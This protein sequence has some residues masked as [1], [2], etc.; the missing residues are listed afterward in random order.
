MENADCGLG[1]G[2]A[3]VKAGADRWQLLREP[4]PSQPLRENPGACRLSWCPP[5]RAHGANC[6]I[7]IQ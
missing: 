3:G 1:G 4:L 5:L 2:S 6:F 7:R